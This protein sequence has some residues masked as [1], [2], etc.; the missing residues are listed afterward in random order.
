[1]FIIDVTPGLG[2]A[3]FWSSRASP[4]VRALAGVLASGGTAGVATVA[5]VMGR[6]R[7]R[8]RP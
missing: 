7:E 5:V 4:V 3:V 1:M 6:R 2:P 8:P